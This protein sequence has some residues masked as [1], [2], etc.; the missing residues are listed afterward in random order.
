MSI[1][2]N[3]KDEKMANAYNSVQFILED[4]EQLH[5][6]G[7]SISL[8]TKKINKALFV[9][10]AEDLKRIKCFLKRVQETSIG[11]YPDVQEVMWDIPPVLDKLLTVTDS[12][13]CTKVM[14]RRISHLVSKI[15]SIEAY[16]F[17][18]RDDGLNEVYKLLRTLD[19]RHV[20]LDNFAE[21]ILQLLH[22]KY[23]ALQLEH[24]GNLPRSLF[25]LWNLE[26]CI[27]EAEKVLLRPLPKGQQKNSSKC[28]QDKKLNS[29]SSKLA[30]H[31]TL[32]ENREPFSFP[33]LANLVQLETLKFEYQTFGME[34]VLLYQGH[35]CPAPTAVDGIRTWVLGLLSSQAQLGSGSHKGDVTLTLF[36]DSCSGILDVFV[37]VLSIFMV[38]MELLMDEK[39]ILDQS[40]DTLYGSGGILGG[41]V[42]RILGDQ[43]NF[44]KRYLKIANLVQKI[45]SVEEL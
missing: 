30:L 29:E 12:H 8:I 26:T 4:L 32:S 40:N 3:S 39:R 19:L 36:F 6:H 44:F 35:G 5:V 27:L 41:S 31:L 45:K 18:Y 25:D 21:E 13:I 11:I 16:S 1:S 28:F 34:P 17:G 10:F 42:I 14:R 7:Q 9:A 15:K 38:V 37:I 24:L 23:L 22:L 33:N 2:M 43:I 20:I